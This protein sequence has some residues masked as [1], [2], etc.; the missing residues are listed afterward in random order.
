MNAIEIGKRLTRLR[1]D[2]T[3]RQVAEDL[4]LSLSAISM[5]ETGERIPRD[6][7][8]IKIAEYYHTT[9]QAI[10]FD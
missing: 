1:G 5:Y 7:H 2:K 4:N 6:G 10:F 3:Q 8:K 9:V